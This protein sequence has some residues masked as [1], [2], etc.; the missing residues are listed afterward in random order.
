M[1]LT[2]TGMEPEEKSPKKE[3]KQHSRSD[4]K[5]SSKKRKGH[6]EAEAEAE[7]EA[8]ITVDTKAAVVVPKVED[9]QPDE[10]ST[11]RTPGGTRYKIPKKKKQKKAT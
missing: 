3:K 8:A 5:G 6:G 2:K 4:Q 9:D 1:W 7:A 10:A 11:P